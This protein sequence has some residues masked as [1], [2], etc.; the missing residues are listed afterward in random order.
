M[1]DLKRQR[2]VRIASPTDV[3]RDK[4]K[5]EEKITAAFCEMSPCVE[6]IIRITCAHGKLKILVA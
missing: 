4:M 3:V 5:N 2:S 1:G 6:Q